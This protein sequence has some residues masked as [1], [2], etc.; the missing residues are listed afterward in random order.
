MRE[1]RFLR[2]Q[3][4]RDN[5][6]SLS[7]STAFGAPVWI[8]GAFTATLVALVIIGGIKRIGA[9]T[10]KLAPATLVMMLVEEGLLS[11]DDPV[12]DRLESWKIVSTRCQVCGNGRRANVTVNHAFPWLQL[13]ATSR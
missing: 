10:S 5:T 3:L 2:N 6:V 4:I 11:L 7:A 13:E 9:V 1:Y 8:S 12:N